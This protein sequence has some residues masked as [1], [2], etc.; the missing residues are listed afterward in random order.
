MWE[1][2]YK[3][4][5]APENWWFWTVVLEKMLQNPLDY[6]EIKPVNPKGNQSWI[7]IG[8]IDAEVETPIFWPPDVKNW[9][10]E[11]DPDAEKDWKQE[12]KGMAENEMVGWHHQLNVNEFEQTPWD[13]EGQ[14]SLA[15]C[16][17]W[18]HKESSKTSI[19]QQQILLLVSIRSI[20]GLPRW[21]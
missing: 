19:K 5:W 4:S 16:S 8:R 18:G 3:E 15:R 14:G 1:L 10:I 17:P 11:K 13:G 21:H 7:F 9:F 12:E 6:K 2:D 20:E